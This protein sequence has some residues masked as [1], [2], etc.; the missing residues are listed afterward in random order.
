MPRKVA[1]PLKVGVL[2][3]GDS[4]ERTISLRSGRAVL[5]GLRTGGF[6]TLSIDPSHRAG[7]RQA[8]Q[9]IDLAFIALHGKG[10][11]DG[12]I[13]ERLEEAG[14]PYIGSDPRG[15]RL[16]FNKAQAKRAFTRAR[17]PTPPWK[18]V[19]R[20]NWQG[21]QSFPTPFF[22]KPVADGSS[23]G[24]FLVEDFRR[25]AENL[26]Q[27]LKQYSMLIAEKRIAGREFTVGIL[28]DRALPV[29]ELRPKSDFYDYHAKYT[30][31]MTEYLVPAPIPEAWRRRFQSVALKVHRVLGLRDLSR[32]DLMADGK[33]RPYVLEANTIPGFT[34]LSLLPKAARQAGISFDDLCL[35]LVRMAWRRVRAHGKT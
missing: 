34:E 30:A 7:L 21:L 31:G 13:Q 6:R 23:I 12:T 8:F 18:L 14:I 22:I 24:V 19:T 17:I 1:S 3:G 2:L 28:G 15:S 26:M 5:K 29:V 10:G 16:A 4:S 20:K 27:A 9:R 25:A 33:G 35:R 32:V 11:E